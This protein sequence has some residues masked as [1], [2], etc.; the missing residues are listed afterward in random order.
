MCAGGHT[1]LFFIRASWIHY[2]CV[3]IIIIHYYEI[4]LSLSSLLHGQQGLISSFFIFLP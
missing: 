4:D 1:L 2:V 3:F